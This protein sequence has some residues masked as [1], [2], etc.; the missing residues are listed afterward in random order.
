MQ[1]AVS[2]LKKRKEKVAALQKQLQD[3]LAASKAMFDD[4]DDLEAL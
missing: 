1:L 2:E 4:E 3:A